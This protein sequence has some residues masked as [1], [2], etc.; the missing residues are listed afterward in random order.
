MPLVPMPYRHRLWMADLHCNRHSSLQILRCWHFLSIVHSHC[1]DTGDT[2]SVFVFLLASK[3]LYGSLEFGSNPQWESSGMRRANIFSFWRNSNVKPQ[4][5][6][7]TSY[8]F[9]GAP[10]WGYFLWEFTWDTFQLL[11]LIEVGW[12]LWRSMWEDST[13]CLKRFLSCFEG[14]EPSKRAKCVNVN[15]MTTTAIPIAPR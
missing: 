1:L 9:F 8:I 12:I 11:K 2:F 14:W 13:I 3:P 7:I 4:T 15:P 10:F 6:I 5:T